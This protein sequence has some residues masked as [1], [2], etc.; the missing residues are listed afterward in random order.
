[1]RKPLALVL[2][3][4]LSLS[5]GGLAAAQ[6]L[7][8]ALAQ[9]EEKKGPLSRL[10]DKV[11]EDKKERDAKKERNKSPPGSNERLAS[12]LPRGKSM[13]VRRDEHFEMPSE[14]HYAKANAAAGV[15]A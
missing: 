11:R 14:E 10:W 5:I 8:P 7:T 2:S 3:L 9:T 12:G 6:L 1:M 15:P 4:T 13:D